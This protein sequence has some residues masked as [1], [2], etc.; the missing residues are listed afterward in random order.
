MNIVSASFIAAETCKQQQPVSQELNL[1][2]WKGEI[3]NKR[4]KRELKGLS[5]DD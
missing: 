4:H 5:N 2:P 3:R 1:H